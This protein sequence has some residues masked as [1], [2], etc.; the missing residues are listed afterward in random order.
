MTGPEDLIMTNI[1]LYFLSQRN[2]TI[3]FYFIILIM[4]TKKTTSPVKLD[5]VKMKS[6]VSE[7]ETPLSGP[8]V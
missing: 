8:Q 2:L 6:L 4:R 3:D 5:G 7:G 1:N